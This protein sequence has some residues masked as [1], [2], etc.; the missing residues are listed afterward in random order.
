MGLFDIFSGGSGP[1]KAQKLK[2]KA[3]QK[4]G[5][6]ATRQKALEQLGAMEIPEAVTALMGRFTVSVDPATTDADEKEHVFQLIS[7]RGGAA[8]E[9]VKQFLMS[10]DAASSWALR[11]LEKIKD[12]GGDSEGLDLIGVVISVLEKVGAGYARDPE[13]KL[14]M[15]HYL[16]EREDPRIVPAVTPFLEDMADD[17]KIAAAKVLARRKDESTREP[18]LKALTAA[19]V[20]KRVQTA[21]VAALAETG[22]GVQGYR[23]KVESLIADPYFIDKSGAVKKRG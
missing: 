9:P 6:P 14:V 11:I 18:M 2:A 20:S 3:T 16:E 5:D 15:L 4:Y 23:E 8:V 10:S 12:G 19:E 21:L 17:V 7:D 13:K 22:F 1:E